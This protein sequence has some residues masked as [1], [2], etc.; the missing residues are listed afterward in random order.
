MAEK[1]GKCKYPMIEDEPCGREL[2]DD[3]HCIFHSK[4]IEG[5][6]NDLE[7]ALEIILEEHKELIDTKS[8]KGKLAMLYGANL[9]GIDLQGVNL[10]GAILIE[11]NLQEVILF[12]AN[13]QGAFLGRAN[14]QDANL[15]K[16]NLVGARLQ[17][18][19]LEGAVLEDADFRDTNLEGANLQKVNLSKANLEGASLAHANLK[20]S[21]LRAA[22]LQGAFLYESNLQGALMIKANL[23]GADLW[24]ANLQGA[25]LVEANLEGTSIRNTNLKNAKLISVSLRNSNVSKVKYNRHGRF[26][27]IRLDGCSGSPRFIKFAKDQ[28]FLEDFR[29]SPWR[30]PIYAIWLILADCGRSLFL[31]AAWSVALAIFFA[32]MFFS[33]GP[34]AFQIHGNLPHSFD[35]ML[36]YSIVTFTTLGFGDITPQTIE[37]S[38]WVMAEV[39]LGY[40]MLGG[41]I[42]IFANKLARRS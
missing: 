5:K 31:W 21:E 4:D 34:G 9:Q 6:R 27:G 41:L 12:E 18:A 36:Y 22:N 33:M 26:R 37:A 23:K 20:G 39:I 11:A 15:I 8:Q 7:I 3:K 2:Y 13:L 10:R 28:E 1:K 38:R 19:D 32:S 16:A 17:K 24:G 40:I 42:S 14:L 30:W 29:S 35:T 25:D